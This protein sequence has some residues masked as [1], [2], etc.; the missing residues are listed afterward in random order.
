MVTEASE[1]LHTSSL[2]DGVG[3]Q[4]ITSRMGAR[5]GHF[6]DTNQ[7]RCFCLCEVQVFTGSALMQ[8]RRMRSKI[9]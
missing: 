5:N 3:V 2:G 6:I 4:T 9:Q 8:E 1:M 7:N